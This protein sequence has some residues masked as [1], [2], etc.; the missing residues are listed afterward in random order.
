[1]DDLRK[2]VKEYEDIFTEKPGLTHLECHTIELSDRQSVRERP[3]P[4]PFATLE[5]VEEEV[6]AMLKE[7]IIERSKSDFC[8]PVVLVKKPDGSFRFCVNYKKLNK[9]TKFDS[10]PMNHPDNILTKLCGKN[11]FSKVDFSRGFW[12][13]PMEEDSKEYTAF[14]TPS[15]C[16]HLPFGLVNSP[17]SYNRMMRKL[18]YGENEIDN[19]VDD[20]LGHT[21][22]WE[23]H[24]AM[25]HRLF[26]RIREAGLTVRPTKCSLGYETVTFLGHT[27]GHGRM[28]PLDN[29]E[30]Q[31]AYSTFLCLRPRSN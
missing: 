10:E 23:D 18:L 30:K 6:Q 22:T 26:T 8:A 3:Y 21:V 12:Q 15:G 27:I 16:Y 19:Y 20:V 11:F 25:L 9:K 1:M 31:S 17:A 29:T 2:L 24:L 4:L 7:G 5:A 14:T 28:T 13:I